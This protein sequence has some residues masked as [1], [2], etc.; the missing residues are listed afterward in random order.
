MVYFDKNKAS[1][2][3][4]SRF[5]S[6]FSVLFSPSLRPGYGLLFSPSAVPVHVVEPIFGREKCRWRKERDRYI[7]LTCL[8]CL[9]ACGRRQGSQDFLQ[10]GHKVP[11][12]STNVVTTHSFHDSGDFTSSFLFLSSLNSRH[13]LITFFFVLL[14]FGLIDSVEHNFAYQWHA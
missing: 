8:L 12:N 2:V 10:L 3:S 14:A 5:L 6:L 9:D 13:F 7:H 1:L 11:T 4:L